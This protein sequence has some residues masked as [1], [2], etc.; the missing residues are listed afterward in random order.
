MANHTYFS[1]T[2]NGK[3][4]YGFST[5]QNHN[6]T[7]AIEH[8]YTVQQQMRTQLQS[9]TQQYRPQHHHSPF[10]YTPPINSK[11]GDPSLHQ[12]ETQPCFSAAQMTSGSY[13]PRPVDM[14]PAISEYSRSN[15]RQQCHGRHRLSYE[16]DSYIGVVDMSRSSTHQ[17]IIS[18]DYQERQVAP[19]PHTTRAQLEFTGCATS[20][21]EDAAPTMSTMDMRCDSTL[22]MK[23][24]ATL[25]YEYN[26]SD[27]RSQSTTEPG[28]LSRM[29]SYIG[30]EDKTFGPAPTFSK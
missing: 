7:Y 23:N 27:T 16:N 22:A 18:T 24:T 6:N 4:A 11:S 8:G 9:P 19:Q 3:Q 17:S 21:L 14:S 5:G 1:I 29:L 10:S 15:E 20:S 2:G 30:G 12:A 28:D 26:I 25:L 13:A